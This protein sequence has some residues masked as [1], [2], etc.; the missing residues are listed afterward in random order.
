[1]WKQ[2]NFFVIIQFEVSCFCGQKPEWLSN[3]C[4]PHLTLL[5]IILY[6]Y[7][8]PLFPY[9]VYWPLA[10]NT[11]SYIL[12]SGCR[13]VCC[14]VISYTEAERVSGGWKWGFQPSTQLYPLPTPTPL[15]LCIQCPLV[16]SVL[17]MKSELACAEQIR[18]S[19][20][21]VY[22]Y[23]QAPLLLCLV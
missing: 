19:A 4:S 2:C 20:S 1:M 13:L 9:Q 12:T 23:K 6:M 17:L 8:T 11:H 5:T 7:T 21:F 15:S 18:Y 3:S 16:H 22:M 14:G 10:L